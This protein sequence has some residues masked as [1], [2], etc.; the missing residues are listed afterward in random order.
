M[1]CVNQQ[2]VDEIVSVYSVQALQLNIFQE[3]LLLLVI[4]C[5]FPLTG[6]ACFDFNL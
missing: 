4:S 6:N 1:N 2:A 5:A 3:F